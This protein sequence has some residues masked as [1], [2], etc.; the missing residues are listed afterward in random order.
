MRTISLDMS[1]TCIG[2]SVWNNDKLLYYTKIKA[3][4]KDKWFQRVSYFYEPLKKIIE[5]YKIEFFQRT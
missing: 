2:I 5:K 4:K 1:T 3:N